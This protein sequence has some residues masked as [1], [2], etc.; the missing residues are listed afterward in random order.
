MDDRTYD[1]NS[2]KLDDTKSGYI[3]GTEMPTLKWPS[4]SERRSPTETATNHR[5]SDRTETSA[6]G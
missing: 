4:I 3:S 2:Q 1:P 5:D 6:N